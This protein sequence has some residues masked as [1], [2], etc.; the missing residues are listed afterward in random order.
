MDPGSIQIFDA[1]PER[2]K[3][4]GKVTVLDIFQNNSRDFHDAG[5]FSSTIFGRVGS[6]ER[7]VRF[8]YIDLY[9]PV[10][11]PR[12]FNRLCSLKQLYKGIM[13]GA[14]YAVWNEADKDFE[15]SDRLN[16]Q[17]GYYFF[18]SHLDKIKFKRTN[19]KLR[20]EKIEIIRQN[21]DKALTTKVLV[22]PAGLRDLEVDEND[23]IDQHEINDLYRSIIRIANN[24]ASVSDTNSH[25]VDKGRYALQIAFNELH[26]YLMTNVTKGKGSFFASKFGRRKLRYGTRSVLSVAS[27]SVKHLD[28]PTN[29][30]PNNTKVGVFQAVKA[31][32][33]LFIHHLKKNY[34]DRVFSG[35]NSAWLIDP[36]TLERVEVRLK[37]RTIDRWTTIEGLTKV[38]NAFQNAHLRKEYVTL[39][40][41]YVGLV[42]RKDGYYKLLHSLDDIPDDKQSDKDHCYPITYGELFFILCNRYIKDCPSDITRYP[43]E[44]SGSIYPSY[45]YLVT[46][47]N[48]LRMTELNDEWVATD[49]ITSQYPNPDSDHWFDTM[50]P[51]PIRL[52]GMGADHDGDMCNNN[53]CYS[54][55]AKRDSLSYLNSMNAHIDSDGGIIAS[56]FID[57]VNMV[58]YNMTGDA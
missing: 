15:K 43:I 25:V 33:P 54:E 35:E 27:T 56:P 36:K 39:D 13:A 30:K 18:L 50:S 44:G 51:H 17:T 42:Y 8:G 22:M 21:M 7:L 1:K 5:L 24:M 41:Y 53:I 46:T 20:D 38:I 47:D 26:D 49:N 37:P 2:L 4:I 32:E 23:G 16:G 48:P 31:T 57:V 34:L 55:E 52:T 40:N 45:S 14:E 29:F 12:I 6:K 11:H 28:D 3:Y 58:I 19:S 9:V 10:L